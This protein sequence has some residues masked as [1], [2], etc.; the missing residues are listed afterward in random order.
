MGVKVMESLGNEKK[1]KTA[2]SRICL[3]LR[4]KPLLIKLTVLP[5]F[6]IGLVLVPW[7]LL[8][9]RLDEMP[10]PPEVLVDIWFTLTAVSVLFVGCVAFIQKHVR[11]R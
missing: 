6:F 8:S 1:R 2:L 7:D 10:S 9:S 11:K 3:S 4:E 5:L